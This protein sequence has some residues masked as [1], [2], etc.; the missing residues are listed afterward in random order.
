MLERRAG[1]E[2]FLN[3]VERMVSTACKEGVKGRDQYFW[4]ADLAREALIAKLPSD[5][6]QSYV[7]LGLRQHTCIRKRLSSEFLP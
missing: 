5:I 7:V 4:N 6:L 3:I 1:E 2:T